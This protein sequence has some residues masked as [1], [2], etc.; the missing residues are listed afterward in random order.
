MIS[1]NTNYRQAPLLPA[2]QSTDE[3]QPAINMMIG[4]W[5]HMVQGGRLPSGRTT[6]SSKA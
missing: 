4:T 5:V 3:P 1:K 2:N 6:Y